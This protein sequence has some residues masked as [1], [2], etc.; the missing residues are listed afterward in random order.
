[1][2]LLGGSARRRMRLFIVFVALAA[3][4]AGGVLYLSPPAEAQVVSLFPRDGSQKVP[5]D[6]AIVAWLDRPIAGDADRLGL[7]LRDQ[8]GRAVEGRLELGSDRKSIIFEPDA[9][10]D[11]GTYL[12]SVRDRSTGTDQPAELS[13]WS[14]AVPDKIPLD[15]GP[16]GSVLL[17]I[18]EASDFSAYYAE[19]LRAEGLNSFETIA[20]DEVTPQVLASHEVA[21]LSAASVGPQVASQISRWVEAGHGNLIA[22]EP[23]GLVAELAGVKNLGRGA[24]DGYI[25]IDTSQAPGTGLVAEPIQFH[26]ESTR[27]QLKDGTRAIASVGPTSRDANESPAITLKTG[28]DGQGM[29]AAYAFDLAKSTVLTRQGNPAWAGQERDGIAPIRPNDLFFGAGGRDFVDLSKVGI[30]QADEHMRLLSNLIGFMNRNNGPMPKFWYFPHFSKAVLVMAAD[31]HGTRNGTAAMFARLDAASPDDCSVEKWECLRATSWLYP[32]S[33]LSTASATNYSDLG[34]DLGAHVTTACGDWDAESLTRAFSDSLGELRQKYPG[35][36]PQTGNRMHCIAWSQWST[37][38]SIE[39][40]WGLRF[41]MNYYYWPGDW[42]QGRSGFMTGSGLPMRFSDPDGKLVNVYQ[43]ETHLVDEVFATNPAAVERLLDRATGPEGYFGAFGTHVD[44]STDFD[45]D[46]LDMA[47]RKSIPMVS[48]K[49]L[50]E[51]TDARNGSSIAA[52]KWDAGEL[53]FQLNVDRGT[54]GML[55]SMLPVDSG[56]GVLRRIRVDGKQLDFT[57]ERVKGLDYAIFAA[58]SGSYVATYE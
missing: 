57:V 55:S 15:R 37:Q 32:D 49:Q 26:G 5:R 11:P 4:A 58:D 54:H 53:S 6:A 16:G 45:V 56:Q 1:M 7:Q 36:P 24:S 50:L 33:G 42:V 14:F 13:T 28:T 2:G 30:P 52:K 19:I 9:A 29:V 51:W 17:I 25:H 40:R 43:Q 47:V 27:L 20:V 46:L 10:L 23:Q 34:F 39:R 21:I 41:D 3:M 18:D 31:D 12:A 48:G 8:R 44:F 22:M 35:L 38:A